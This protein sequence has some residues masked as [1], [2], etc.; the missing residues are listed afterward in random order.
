MIEN[1]DYLLVF[2]KTVIYGCSLFSGGTLLFLYTFSTETNDIKVKLFSFI[3]RSSFLGITL[4]VINL[5]TQVIWLSAGEIDA[6]YD[7]DMI[8]LVASSTAGHAQIFLGL[9]LLGIIS[10]SKIH[11]P[12]YGLLILL[13]IP[14]SYALS[15]HTG[16]YSPVWLLKIFIIVHL[17]ILCF[18]VGSFIPLLT[19]ID[20][21]KQTAADTSER[22]GNIAAFLIPL[23]LA[24]GVGMTWFIVGGIKGLTTDYGLMLLGKLSLVI[25]LLCFAAINKL[26]LVPQ[27]KTG[28]PLAA[29]KLKRSIKTEIVLVLAI[30]TLT[31]VITTVIPPEN[32]G[33]RIG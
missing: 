24:T 33:H 15:G 2:L 21:K 8:N 18:W 12:V 28:H 7:P 31:A 17:S 29:Q 19:L 32:L 22:F 30:L 5:G 6:L 27:L 1:T 20:Q 9:G 3:T 23:L 25:L 4:I 26:R 16:F 10:A 11:H 14:T 13:S